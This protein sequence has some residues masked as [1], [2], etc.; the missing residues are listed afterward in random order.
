MGGPDL[1]DIQLSVLDQVLAG[2]LDDFRSLRR[3]RQTDEEGRS[4]DVQVRVLGQ[5]LCSRAATCIDEHMK[6]LRKET[7]T[8]VTT[9][10]K[11]SRKVQI[12]VADYLRQ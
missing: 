8:K 4:D 9:P 6:E 1:D 10:P 2:G 7:K 3:R 12:G 5:V 11:T